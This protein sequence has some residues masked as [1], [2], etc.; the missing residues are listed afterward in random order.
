[1][2]E[3]SLSESMA[4]AA[5]RIQE[6]V[7]AAERVAA[8]IRAEAEAEADRYLEARRR[9]AD[10]L[11]VTRSHELQELSATIV[12]HATRVKQQAEELVRSLDAAIEK[13][14]AAPPSDA[15]AKP[16]IEPRALPDPA[17][18]PRI[19]RGPRPIAYSGRPQAA[20]DPAPEPAPA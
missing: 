19:E 5:D 18:S 14:S 8:D 13:M 11:T 10:Q 16:V 6:I 2:A 7:D 4:G 3:K 9:D 1:M 17:P 20:P 15:A 12:G